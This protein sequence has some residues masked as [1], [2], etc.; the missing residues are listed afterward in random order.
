MGVCQDGRAGE[1]TQVT[2]GK[3]V[4]QVSAAVAGL[5]AAAS[6]HKPSQGKSRGKSRTNSQVGMLTLI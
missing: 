6:A 4:G 3:G 5:R 1:V 2:D